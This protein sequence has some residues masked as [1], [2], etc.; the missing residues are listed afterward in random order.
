MSIRRTGECPIFLEYVT[1]QALLPQCGE[2]SEDFR[3]VS[4]YNFRWIDIPPYQRGLVWDEEPLENLLDSRSRFLGNAILGS[5]EIPTDNPRFTWVPNGVRNY[6]ILVDGLQRFSLGTAILALLHPRVI[7]SDPHHPDLQP[8]F[9]ALR[10]NCANWAPVYL[11]NDRELQNH[12][13][14][15]VSSSYREFRRMLERWIGREFNENRTADLA[16]RLNHLFLERQIAPDTYY[17]FASPYDV[18]ATFIGL[19]TVRVQLSNVDWLRSLIVDQGSRSGWSPGD[20]ELIENRFT[21]V[22]TKDGK[23]PQTDLLPF[24]AIV[25]D[26]LEDREEDS[27]ARVFAGWSKQQLT[28]D[29][30]EAFLGF[31]ERVSLNETNPYLEEIRACG[32]IPFAGVLCN[33]YRAYLAGDG[34]PSFITGG[35]SESHE[36]REYLRANYRALF[37]GRIG[38]TRGHAKRLLLRDDSL[39]V[40]AEA[41]SQ[42]FLACSLAS[43]VDPDWLKSA[44]RQS[45]KKR[46]ARV[47]NACLLAERSAEA[48][49]FPIQ[50]Y[51]LKSTEYQIDHLYPESAIMIHKDGEAEVNRLMNF[52][53]IRR[54][55][56]IAQSNLSCALKL[57][58]G[59]MLSVELQNDENAHPYLDWLVKTQGRH[60]GF[61][62]QQAR[63]MPNQPPGIA[64]ERIE[65]L[66]SRLITRL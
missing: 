56:N 55:A 54:T 8:L 13:R 66:T 63:L 1:K 50:E 6:E 26:A 10:T 14:Y 30:V 2:P 19:N 41:I 49:D 62:D 25:K 32:A 3:S 4:K 15:C 43:S 46:A 61:L 65:W 27:S 37:N 33:Y 11:H 17:G 47:F 44:L 51:G 5:F 20:I 42:D 9:S 7:A 58:P 36:L 34:D 64:D 60:G 12:D 21:E 39:E 57:A 28:V 22:F 38:R 29:E 23:G 45:D 52:A 59:G 18:S 31:V 48:H 40:V 35:T 16:G 24:V 53:P